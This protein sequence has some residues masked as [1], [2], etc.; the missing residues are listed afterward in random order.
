MV[1]VNDFDTDLL[2]PKMKLLLDGDLSF[3]GTMYEDK[4]I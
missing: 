1:S 4:I 2:Y 3:L